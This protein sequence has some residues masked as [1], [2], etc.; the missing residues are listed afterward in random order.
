MKVEVQIKIEDS[1]IG[2]DNKVT[3]RTPV[4]E[5]DKGLR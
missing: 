2:V 1:V 4:K 5:K 3:L